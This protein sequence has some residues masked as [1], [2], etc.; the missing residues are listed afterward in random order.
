MEDKITHI[1][2]LLAYQEQQLQELSDVVITQGDEIIV[3]KKGLKKA[4]DKI[5]EL[6]LNISD[7]KKE[8]FLSVT[9]M[10]NHDKPPHY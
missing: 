7:N 3:L 10:A 6:E 2:T 9:E 5:T 8:G 4:N 1:E